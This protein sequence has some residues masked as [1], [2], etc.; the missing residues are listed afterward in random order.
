M[1]PKEKKRRGVVRKR[2][3][4]GCVQVEEEKVGPGRRRVWPG[5]RRGK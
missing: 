1:G 3:E 4:E 5:G 2:N